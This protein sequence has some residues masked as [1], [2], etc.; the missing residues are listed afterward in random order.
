MLT[1]VLA[2][3]TADIQEGPKV[4]RP[5]L[6]TRGVRPYDEK[7][8]SVLLDGYTDCKHHQLGLGNCPFMAPFTAVMLRWQLAQ[9]RQLL[10]N[11]IK[12]MMSKSPCCHS[13][14]LKGFWSIQASSLVLQVDVWATGI[15][16]YELVVGRPPFEVNDEVQTAT[17]IMFSNNVV[18]PPKFSALWADFVKV[19]LEKKPHIRPTALQMLDHPWY[20]LAPDAC[21]CSECAYMHAALECVLHRPLFISGLNLSFVSAGVHI[22]SASWNQEVHVCIVA[23]VAAMTAFLWNCTVQFLNACL[24]HMLSIIGHECCLNTA[25]A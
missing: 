24:L 19:A 8:Q 1:Q 9:G 14:E 11:K 23:T 18:Y 13:D 2:N 6:K 7:V 21:R 12:D 20:T 25:R 4:T 10:S 3:P 5:E 17:M 15:L 16:A 22:A